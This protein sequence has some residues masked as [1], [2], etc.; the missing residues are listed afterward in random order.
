VGK[1][2]GHLPL[3]GSKSTRECNIKVDLGDIM[4]GCEWD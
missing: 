3:V 2:P 4:W 1:P